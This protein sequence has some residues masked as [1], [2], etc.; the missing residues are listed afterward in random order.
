MQTATRHVSD[1]ALFA[2]ANQGR[3]YTI[4]VGARQRCHVPYA[5]TA[6]VT[7]ELM[8]DA[9]PGVVP[10]ID[11]ETPSAATAIMPSPVAPLALAPPAPVEPVTEAPIHRPEGWAADASHVYATGA[12]RSETA[13]R[14]ARAAGFATEQPIFTRG[15]RVNDLGVSNA[16][17]A[18]VEYDAMPGLDLAC[19]DL[20]A[21]VRAEDRRDMTVPRHEV[22]MDSSGRLVLP[23]DR[24]APVE[25][26]AFRQ[27]CA[28]LG[29]GGDLVKCWPKLR[30]ANFNAWQR[31]LRGEADAE[32]TAWLLAEGR[33]M[34][35]KDETIVLRTRKTPEGPRGVFGVVTERYT[36][37]DADLLAEAVKLALPPDAKCRVT[38]DG[39]RAKLEVSFHTT[40]RPDDF[41]AGEFFRAGITIRTDD[42]GGGSLV[43]DSWLEMNKCLNLLIIAHNAQPIFRL[44]HMGEVRVLARKIREGIA[45]GEKSLA[46]FLGAWGYAKRDDLRAAALARGELVEGMTM[47]EAF[48]ALANG[49]IER[50]LVPVR[51]QRKEVLRELLDMWKHDTSSDGPGVGT[52]T[53]SGLVNSFTR[54]AHEVNQDAFFAGEV[55]RSASALLWPASDRQT[56]PG[57]IQAIPF[58]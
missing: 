12:A 30:A 58:G 5:E 35:N 23:G 41:V 49:V 31:A 27:L 29:F 11:E 46:H 57:I 22:L 13:D 19:D 39:T 43:G 16:R 45:K 33:A 36:P 25:E 38:Y 18:R 34:G 51:G 1:E 3:L 24:R 17:A 21:T 40:V 37:F 15:T 9:L 44:R 26:T 10:C 14:A 8:R 55:E 50:E 6:A 20:V 32:V 28:R 42:T 7:A 54:W 52:V 56:V 53:R 4:T 48:S 2:L 47:S